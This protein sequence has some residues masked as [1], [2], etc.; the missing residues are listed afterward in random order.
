MERLTIGLEES[1]LSYVER[2]ADERD[3]SRAAVVRRIIDE[4][5]SG[6][7]RTE[8]NRTDDHR[9]DDHRIDELEQRVSSLENELSDAGASGDSDATG[10]TVAPVSD[11]LPQTVDARDAS[12][13]IESVLAYLEREG[14]ASKREI[15]GAV[16]PEHPLSY[17]VPDLNGSGRYRGAWWRR[18]IK[19]ALEGDERVQKPK[20]GGSDWRW[21]G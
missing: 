15:V 2:L 17:D 16:M 20:P 10:E 13:A 12:D 4:H 8:S 19:P 5:Q 21:V 18:V 11:D 6:D 9:T 3:R 7:H 14:A 1:Q